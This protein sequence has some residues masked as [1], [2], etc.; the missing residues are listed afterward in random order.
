MFVVRFSRPQLLDVT[1]RTTQHPVDEKSV[2]V[3]ADLRRYPGS[4][5][6]E[7]GGQSLA[8]TEDSLEARKSDLYVLPHSVAP[9]GWLGGQKDADLGQGLS[10][11]LTSVGQVSA[12]SLLATS[13]PKAASLM[14]SSVRETS[15]TLAGVSS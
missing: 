6:N 12:K 11:L 8:Q 5:P 7:R 4:Q 3:G 10:E 2:G 9:L 1:L 14:S 13:S 15:A